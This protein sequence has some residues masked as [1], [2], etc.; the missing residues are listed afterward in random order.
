MFIMAD[1]IVSKYIFY[2]NYNVD[3]F[4]KNIF[5]AELGSFL[6]ANCIVSNYVS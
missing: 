6:T 4:L 1:C 5:T 3:L 2:I